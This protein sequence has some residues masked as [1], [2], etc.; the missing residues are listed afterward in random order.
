MRVN[1]QKHIGAVVLLPNPRSLLGQQSVANGRLVR[2]PAHFRRNGAPK[3][4]IL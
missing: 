1:I 2:F 4:G 3:N